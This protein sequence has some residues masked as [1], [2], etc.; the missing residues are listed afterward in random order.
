MEAFHDS[1]LNDP[2][3]PRAPDEYVSFLYS[4]APP[5][6]PSHLA[7]LSDVARI[8][9]GHPTYLEC[10]N[11]EL[12]VNTHKMDLLYSVRTPNGGGGWWGW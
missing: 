9:A 5:C 4:V 8:E 2:N 1:L 6:L 12:L 11:A 7:I 3:A 10:E